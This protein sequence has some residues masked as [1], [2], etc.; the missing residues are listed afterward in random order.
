MALSLFPIYIM[1]RDNLIWI[2]L[3]KVQCVSVSLKYVLRNYEG[4]ERIYD[5]YRRHDEIP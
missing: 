5:M 2:H 4:I 3:S 1:E